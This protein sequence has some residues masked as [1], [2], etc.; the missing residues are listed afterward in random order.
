MPHRVYYYSFEFSNQAAVR[1]AAKPPPPPIHMQACL[2]FIVFFIYTYVYIIMIVSGLKYSPRKN[3]QVL[4]YEYC[5]DIYIIVF[6][7][8]TVFI[9]YIYTIYIIHIYVCEGMFYTRRVGMTYNMQGEVFF[10][11]NSLLF[12]ARV[13]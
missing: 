12:F 7:V 9:L 6:V 4:V 13:I 10:L 2:R 11:L 5:R 8:L 1:N 3:M